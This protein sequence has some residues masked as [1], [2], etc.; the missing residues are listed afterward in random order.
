ML[1]SGIKKGLPLSPMLFIFY[2]NDMFEVFRSV[3]RSGVK[4]M[5]N[6]IHLLIHADDLTL[7]GMLRSEVIA[8][9]QTLKQYCTINYIRPQTTKCKFITINGLDIDNGPKKVSFL[10][11]LDERR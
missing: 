1:F 5:F 9:L 2:V 7:L 10:I 4:N 11:N 6:T 8:K 3:F